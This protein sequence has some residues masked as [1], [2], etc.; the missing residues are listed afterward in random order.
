MLSNKNRC[1]GSSM[2]YQ[3]RD[4]GCSAWA[5]AKGAPSPGATSHRRVKAYFNFASDTASWRFCSS[6]QAF[7]GAK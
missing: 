2:A 3:R 7:S 5:P 1:V 4:F 6:S